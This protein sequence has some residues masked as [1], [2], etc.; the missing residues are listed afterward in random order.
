M[1]LTQRCSTRQLMTGCGVA[2]ALGL[3][4]GGAALIAARVRGDFA[5]LPRLAFD[6]AFFFAFFLPPIIFNAGLSVEKA[7]LYH[8]LQPVLLL[9]VLGTMVNCIVVAAGTSFAVDFLGG[10]PLSRRDCL[11][12]G[13]TF[14]A[15]DTVA[16]L[17]V[18]SPTAAPSLFALVLGEGCINDAMSLVLLRALE[19]VPDGR[20]AL[21]A[22]PTSGGMLALA[23]RFVY[24]LIASAI[25]GFAVGIMACA[26]AR[27]V[28]V[29]LSNASGDVVELEVV[30]ISLV[31]YLAYLLAESLGLSGIL[32]IFVAALAISHYGLRCISRPARSVTLHAVSALSFMSEITIFVYTGIATLDRAVWALARPGEVFALVSSVGALLLA[33]RALTVAAVAAA[34][35][36]L[37]GPSSAAARGH[38]PSAP[39]I[40]F[41]EAG[42]VWWAGSMRGA[43]SVAIATHH[44]A[45][46]APGRGAMHLPQP[47]TPEAEELRTRASVIAAT[48][49][50]VLGSTMFFSAGTRP[51]LLRVL[52]EAV[53]SMDGAHGAC[54][55]PLADG[56]HVGD[57]PSEAYSWLQRMWR[58]MDEHYLAPLLLQ[59]PPSNQQSRYTELQ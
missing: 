7:A 29:R 37:Q 57:A 43:V 19:A 53:A 46:A 23:A 27:Y 42:V 10:Y 11:A 21:A 35:I 48:F 45:V 9:G 51:F 12:L 55:S 18:L 20:T 31:A 59:A 28:N 25:L 58:G 52:P 5:L 17:Q 8:H 1:R 50:I 30:V 41:R 13:A 38:D 14:G 32:S 34:G 33:S 47:N 24:L 36:W 3:V 40:S 2:S 6:P 4:V 54:T 39:C 44:F 16:T 49:I 26:A 56:D 22:R 15:T